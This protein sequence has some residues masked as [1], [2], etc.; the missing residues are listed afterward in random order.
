MLVAQTIPLIKQQVDLTFKHALLR[1]SFGVKGQ[2]INKVIKIE[3][4][5]VKKS[6]TVTIGDDISWN[7]TGGDAA[8]ILTDGAGIDDDRTEFDDYTNITTSNGY[9]MMIP[10]TFGEDARF[11]IT[12]IDGGGITKKSEIYFSDTKAWVAG[13]SYTYNFT[14]EECVFYGTIK[15]FIRLYDEIGSDECRRLTKITFTDVEH[16]DWQKCMP[17]FNDILKSYTSPFS[18]HMPYFEKSIAPSA[19][20]DCIYLKSFSAPQMLAHIRNRSFKGC[21]SL[22][23]INLPEMKGNIRTRAFEGCTNLEKVKCPNMTGYLEDSVF[24]GCTSLNTVILSLNGKMDRYI[25][26]NCDALNSITLG[27]AGTDVDGYN[28]KINSHAFNDFDTENCILTFKGEPIGI[29]RGNDWTVK[30]VLSI[31]D[32]QT[33][34]DTTWMTTTF[35]FKNITKDYTP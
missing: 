14:S 30:Q 10:Q 23:V 9:L 16:K 29:I 33:P 27:A 19:F 13:E 18:V 32:T 31:D 21:T 22:E 15:D 11:T 12:Y 28:Y 20:E 5:G 7:A 2:D 17:K 4:K 1:I 35:T 8:F 24:Y 34:P 25:F 6:G 26:A 3:V